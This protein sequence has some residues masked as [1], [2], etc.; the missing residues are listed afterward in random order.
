MYTIEDISDY[1]SDILDL[2]YE[3]TYKDRLVFNHIQLQ[4]REIRKYT[5]KI[6]N[7]YHAPYFVHEIDPSTLF[8]SSFDIDDV[9][10]SVSFSTKLVEFQKKIDTK[11]VI[12]CEIMLRNHPSL[13][14]SIDKMLKTT[15]IRLG[16]E[17]NIFSKKIST[18]HH[19]Y[20]DP[21]KKWRDYTIVMYNKKEMKSFHELIEKSKAD[22]DIEIIDEKGKSYKYT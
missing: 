10:N 14:Q 22:N 2:R 15:L 16:R 1:F 17:W 18:E 20:N 7:R 21:K 9:P 6:S 12:A 13:D 11:D 4:V 3:M 8:K 19:I 5:A